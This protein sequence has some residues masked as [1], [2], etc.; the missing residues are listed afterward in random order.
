MKRQEI[1]TEVSKYFTI[2]ELVCPHIRDKFGDK[3][4]QFISTPLLETLLILRRDILK[5]PMVINSGTTLTQR[6]VRCNLC[7]I[8]KEKTE[9]DKIYMSAHCLGEALD[10]DARGYSAAQVRTIIE[11]NKAKLPYNCRMEN[12]VT[13]CHIDMYD[14]GVKLYLFNA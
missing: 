2:K 13:W 11:Q 1:I 14:T 4:W 5:V 8:V 3:S 12:D 7:S 6:G 10:F 9:K